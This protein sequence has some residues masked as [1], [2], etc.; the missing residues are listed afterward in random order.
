MPR[1]M[2]P[3]EDGACVPR[4]ELAPKGGAALGA[5]FPVVFVPQHKVMEAVF[6]DLL[7]H[8]VFGDNEWAKDVE[9][10]RE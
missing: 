7:Q 3:L 6:V 2:S 1:G 9:V 4:G 8:E 10:L 5:V